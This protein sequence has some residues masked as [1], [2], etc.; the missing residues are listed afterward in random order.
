MTGRALFVALKSRTKPA[1]TF[2]SLQQHLAERLP[3]ATDITQS[4][5]SYFAV[6]FPTAEDRD[7]GERTLRKKVFK[8]GAAEVGLTIANFGETAAARETIWQF[9]SSILDT[10]NQVADAVSNFLV[11]AATPPEGN[12]F[13]LRRLMQETAYLNM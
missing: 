11:T 1:E 9:P 7:A 8:L 12:S 2:A 6:L 10:P 3:K 5:H 13:E 4:E